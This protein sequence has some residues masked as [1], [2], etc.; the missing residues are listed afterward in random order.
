MLVESQYKNLFCLMRLRMKRYGN[1][2]H[3][4]RGMGLI[5]KENQMSPLCNKKPPQEAPKPSPD[6]Q[7]QKVPGRIEKVGV[8][9]GPVRQKSSLG[10]IFK[11]KFI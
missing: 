11:C 1:S 4:S 6:T 2:E 7:C 10:L 3:N 9:E 5:Q 8:G